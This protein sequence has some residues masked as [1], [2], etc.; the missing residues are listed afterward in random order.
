MVRALTA[1]SL[2]AL[3]SG[4]AF[5]QSAETTPTFTIAD[6]HPSAPTKN[7]NVFM[8]GGVVRGGRYDLRHAT[9]LDL[10]STAWGIDADRVYGGPSWLELDRFEIAAKTPPNTSQET[11]KL[12]LQALLKERFHLVV[13]MDTKTAPGFE[14]SL[15]KGK[16]KMKQSDGSGETGCQGVP[17]TAP[18]APGT[19]PINVVRCSNETMEAFARDLR[20]MANAYITTAVV[21]ST[22]LKEGWDFELKWTSRA[23]LALAGSDAISIYDAV[24]K[25]LGLKLEAKP[26]PSQ[27]LV[28]DSVD[29]TPTPNPPGVGPGVLPPP[30]TEFDV[31]DIKPSMPD[32]Q[33]DGRIQPGGRL[34]LHA[35]P[36]KQLIQIA[37][38]INGDETLVGGPKFLDT[39]KFDI[40]AKAPGV[41]GTG[42]N[43]QIDIDDILAMLQ[44]LLKDRFKLAVHTEDRPINAYVLTAVKPKLAKADPAGRTGCK[45]GPA[46][47]GKDP[48]DTAPILSR[49]LTCRNMTMAQFGEQLPILASGYVHTTVKDETGLE[50]AYD[51]TL[52]FSAAGLLTFGAGGRGGEPAAPGGA[53]SDA[54][55]PTGALSLND[56][57]SKQ[58]GLKLEMRKRP[59]E[60]LVID[61]VEESPTAN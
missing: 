8:S 23:L 56:A 1:L 54:S 5:G 47:G 3:V 40:I 51:F 21:D 16:P 53:G 20:N 19:I 59:V 31:A 48:R 7:P 46:V 38:N 43:P 26:V 11:A 13:H 60:V 58:L 27:V 34:D 55:L 17:Q 4:A 32:A 10:V 57:I 33:T 30:P 41:T 12:M 15:G 9:M 29:K 36:L 22:G 61:H 6:V 52:S 49:L 45:E 39:A 37:W 44:T 24:D 2:I 50:G 25:Q 42:I 35:F 14:L 18:S 28:V